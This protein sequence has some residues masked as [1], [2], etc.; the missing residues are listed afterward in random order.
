MQ[1]IKLTKVVS[2]K[3][4]SRR[5]NQKRKLTDNENL[6]ALLKLKIGARVM[7]TLDFN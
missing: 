1:L 3:E 7:L 6:A 4:I 5:E 2:L